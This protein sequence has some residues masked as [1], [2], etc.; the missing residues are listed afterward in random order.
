M[1]LRRKLLNILLLLLAVFVIGTI[2]YRIIGFALGKTWSLLDCAYMSIIT[3]STVGYEDFLGAHSLLAAKTFTMVLIVFGIGTFFYSVS[4]LTASLVEMDIAQLWR[5]RKMN[6]N[7][8]SLR[9]HFILCGVGQTGIHVASELLTTGHPFVA[10]EIDPGRIKRLQ[11][12]GD[13][14]FIQGNATDDEN[15]K[16]AGVERASGLVAALSTDRDNLFITI[17]ARQLNRS[18]RIVSRCLDEATAPKF[19]HAGANAVV[20]PN[21]LGGVRIASELIRPTVVKFLDV[22]MADHEKA[23]RVEDAVVPPNS[24]LAGQSLVEAAIQKRTGTLIVALKSPDAESFTYSPSADAKLAPGT[25]LIVLGPV[26]NIKKLRDLI[27][28]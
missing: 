8:E 24:P 6:N 11:A 3:L 14:P 16:K 19:Y 18:M 21:V 1:T 7:I 27:G 12:L 15:L 20:S 2:G 13:V 23:I 17:S 4:A 9:D 5:K 28:P 10:V 25:L 26:D 22:M